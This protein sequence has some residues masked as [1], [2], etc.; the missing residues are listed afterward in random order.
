MKWE[1][2]LE[3]CEN[4]RLG[5]KNDWRLPT[6]KELVSIVKDGELNPAIDTKYFPNTASSSY[7]S[8][9]TDAS[10]TEDAWYVHFSNGNVLNYTKSNTY[11]VRCV[12]GGQ[13]GSFGHLAISQE[14]RDTTPPEITI[15][16]P[17]V[18]RGIKRRQ[19][20]DKILVRGTAT[21]KSGVFEV[22]VNNTKAR[23]LTNNRFEALVLLRVGNNRITVQASDIR[24][25]TAT[26]EFIIER[27]AE[28]HIAYTPPPKPVSSSS[29]LT[30]WYSAQY[31][32][33][34]GIDKY[35]DTRI[36]TLRNAVNDA[37]SVSKMF[38]KLGFDVT[39]L[40][41]S[42]ATKKNIKKAIS[43]I[44]KKTGRNDSFVFYF[45]GHGQGIKLES[46]D[47]E[48]YIIPA[49]ADL[50]MD[51]TDIM[52]YDDEAISLSRLRAYSK[53]IKAKLIALILDSC[54]SGLA[55]KRAIPQISGM[56]IEYYNDL[57][58]RKAINILTAG[59]DHPVSDGTGH[60]PFTRSLLYALDKGN[61]DMHD[62]DGFA[63]FSQLSV[64]VKEKVEKSTGRRQRPQFDNLSL[65][66]GDFVFKIR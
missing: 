48:G 31:A 50:E 56:D 18:Q 42:K 19:K 6:I 5:G 8:S 39:E 29:G 59:D 2:A 54:F 45:A 22:L 30:G 55:M 57:L 53:D 58:K 7:W 16:E 11:Y 38:R 32:I 37:K 52:Q 40:Y 63:T 62:R 9:S 43:E 4:L 27:P 10:D 35:N 12:R 61:L 1:N 65:D 14:K 15:T 47:Q 64:Y 36:E 51:S 25:N 49:D 28:E 17:S 13:S 44:R 3:Y 33:V 34:I 24:K 26:K 46:K 20:A 23:L 60:S 41:N 21:D 66:D